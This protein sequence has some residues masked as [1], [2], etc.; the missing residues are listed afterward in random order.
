[1]SKLKTMVIFSAGYVLG[2]QAGRA[3][4]EEIKQQATRLAEHPKTKQLTGAAKEQLSTRLPESVTTKLGLTSTG[5]STGTATT[6]MPSTT[7]TPSTTTGGAD[8]DRTVDGEPV[9]RPS[10]L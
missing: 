6:S 3:R 8:L 7:G 2:A 5:T 1:M 4:Y 10:H 9:A